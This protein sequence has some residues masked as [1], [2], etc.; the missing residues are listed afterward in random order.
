LLSTFEEVWNSRKIPHTP[1]MLHTVRST[2]PVS[3]L[4]TDRE[5]NKQWRPTEFE[6]VYEV[7]YRAWLGQFTPAE[8]RGFVDYLHDDAFIVSHLPIGQI[9]V[10]RDERWVEIDDPS[11]VVLATRG[12]LVTTTGFEIVPGSSKATDL[13]LMLIKPD[14]NHD[15]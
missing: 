8:C 12:T 10:K 6:V 9:P 4:I 7:E 2:E 3:V 13:E 11:M 14:E 5:G 15:G 1:G